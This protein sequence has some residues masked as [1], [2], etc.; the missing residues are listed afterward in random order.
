MWMKQTPHCNFSDFEGRG[1]R[2]SFK[3][4]ST[5]RKE[6]V[7]IPNYQLASKAFDVRHL[8]KFLSRVNESGDSV[9]Q[10][11]QLLA[12]SNSRQSV[13]KRENTMADAG[14]EEPID[15]EQVVMEYGGKTAASRNG[16]SMGLVQK[17][18]GNSLLK[19]SSH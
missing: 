10:S 3:A 15:E 18:N 13:Q 5:V 7:D 9:N 1:I 6:F 2:T 11:Y 8:D 19:R 16:G 4:P 14:I 12:M 17:L